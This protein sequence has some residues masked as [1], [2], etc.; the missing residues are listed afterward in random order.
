MAI[1]GA[2]ISTG[3]GNGEAQVF[4]PFDASRHLDKIYAQNQHR[5]QQQAQ[6]EQK[7]AG[8]LG[9]TF[10]DLSKIDIMFRDQ[11]Y[12]AEKQKAIR[13]W[14]DA[15]NA[16]KIVK[17]GDPQATMELQRMVQDL[18]M[19]AKLSKNAREQFEG[20]GKTLYA[21]GSDAFTSESRDYY[22]KFG[23]AP[24]LEKGQKPDWNFD[25]S[26]IRKEIPFT[27]IAEEAQKLKKENF[28][29][30]GG[31]VNEKGETVNYT[32]EQY[33]RQASDKIAAMVIKNPEY[34]DKFHRMLM[35]IPEEEQMLYA[36]KDGKLDV[37]KFAQDQ[38]A[39]ALEVKPQTVSHITKGSK[40]NDLSFENGMASNGKYNFVTQDREQEVPTPD[41]L[42]KNKKKAIPY[43]VIS[44]QR[45]DAGE[46]KGFFFDDPS[47]EGK[48][49]EVIPKEYEQKENGDW[50]LVGVPKNGGKEVRIPEKDITSDMKAITGVD[51][52]E[53]LKGD[54]K[55]QSLEGSKPVENEKVVV[56]KDGKKYK[57]PKSQLNSALKQGYKI[58]Q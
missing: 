53:L 31:Y 42:D 10:H 21:A 52:N 14:A 1:D 8:D 19:E 22:L 28:K 57:L 16:A 55:G 13:D 9:K 44:I 25:S 40:G 29:T 56:M 37:V 45:T 3:E 12:F 23:E 5:A 36:D 38:L 17:D 51:L 15:G 49:V 54:K 24:K 11:P 26:K 7:R 2:N 43:K 6:Q 18:D 41:I 47:R 30:G 27:K 48:K 34:F 35:N 58:S 20:F 33:P 4:K 46:N 50:V 39:P 32:Q